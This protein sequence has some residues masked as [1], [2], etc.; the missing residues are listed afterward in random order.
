M[1]ASFPFTCPNGH[2]FDAVAKLRARCP[3][4]GE[5]ARRDFKPN[6]A[7]VT[8]VK[9]LTD[10]VTT[11]VVKKTTITTPV[12]IRQGRARKEALVISTPRKPPVV[13]KKPI[14]PKKPIRTAGRVSAGLV[15]KHRITRRGSMPVVNQRPVK[16]AIARGIKGHEY[17]RPFWHEVADKYG[18]G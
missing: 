3:D 9:E 10:T 5:T 13:A 17:T 11:P 8:P 18:I 7:V 4:C 6:K 15:K 16:T 2:H 1:P 14:V 12:L